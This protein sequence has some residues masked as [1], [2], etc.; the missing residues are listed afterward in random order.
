MDVKGKNLFSAYSQSE[1]YIFNPPTP[2]SS[3][4]KETI[5]NRCGISKGF[6]KLMSRSCFDKQAHYHKKHKWVK[7]KICSCGH[8]ETSHYYNKGGIIQCSV[9]DCFPFNRNGHKQIKI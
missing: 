8:G 5:C 6:N 1:V 2:M 9:G 3:M 7:E 4:K